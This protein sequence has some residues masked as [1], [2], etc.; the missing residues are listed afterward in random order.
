[1]ANKFKV[2]L[3]VTGF[4][5]EIEGSRNDVVRWCMNEVLR[6]FW[7]GDR[8]KVAQTIRELLQFDVP[9]IGK[10]EEII[11]VQ[12]TDLTAEEEILVLLHYAGENGFN[13][14]ELGCYSQHSPSSVTNTLK[15][16]SSPQYRETILLS[17]GNYRLTDLGCKRL[18]EQLTDKLLLQ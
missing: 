2:K 10:F 5:L 16:L 3:K 1:M 12:R 8:E 9:C 18:R 14:K 11:L 13:R 15:K 6:I 4:E 17:S 7:Q